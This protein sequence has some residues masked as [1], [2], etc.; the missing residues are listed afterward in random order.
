MQLGNQPNYYEIASKSAGR[1][2]DICQDAGS[3]GKLILY[4]S[5]GGPNQQF[6]LIASDLDVLI[7]SK[8]SG[9]YLTVANYSDKNGAPLQEEAL[10]NLPSQKFRLQEIFP[11][12]EEYVIF[13]FCG[14]S[15]D[16]CE[17]ETKNN[18]RI[19]QWDFHAKDNQKWKLKRM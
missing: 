8:A 15:L 17:N 14:K 4:D 10:N 7:R 13:T 16:C 18:T 11:G 5:W 1:V 9:L 12:S 6:A 2:L 3:K 19:I